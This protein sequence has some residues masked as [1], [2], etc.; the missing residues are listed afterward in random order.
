MS[1]R[2]GHSFL[3]AA[4]ADVAEAALLSER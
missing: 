1:E 3:L 2:I 4:S